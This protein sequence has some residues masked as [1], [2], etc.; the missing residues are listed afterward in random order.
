MFCSKPTGTWWGIY[1]SRTVHFTTSDL[2][3]SSVFYSNQLQLFISPCLPVLTSTTSPI[4]LLLCLSTFVSLA[5]K[6]PK[7]TSNSVFMVGEGMNALARLVFPELHCVKLLPFKAHTPQFTAPGADCALVF[8]QH[9]GRIPTLVCTPS[10][11]LAVDNSS[12]PCSF[13]GHRHFKPPTGIT[14]RLKSHRPFLNMSWVTSKDNYW[15]WFP[16]SNWCKV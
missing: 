2:C 11:F 14:H 6:I 5:L 7:G 13:Q 9:R 10:G 1:H 12:Q 3:F 16:S 15:L 8:V 4:L